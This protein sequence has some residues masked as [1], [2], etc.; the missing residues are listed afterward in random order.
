MV[1]E[2]KV[3]LATPYRCWLRRKYHF[4][5]GWGGGTPKVLLKRTD[6]H[7]KKLV[8]SEGNRI[9]PQNHQQDLL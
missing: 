6:G 7:P 5:R 9:C 3:L 2:T 1:R 4:V 8:L